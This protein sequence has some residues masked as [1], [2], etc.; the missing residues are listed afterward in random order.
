[1]TETKYKDYLAAR[2][3][4]ESQPVTY[5]LLSRAL[6]VN[7]SA[8]KLML[9]EFHQ[10]QNARKPNSIHATY[11]ISG[12]KRTASEPNGTNGRNGEDVSMRSSPFMS[13]MPGPEE[14]EEEP[15]KKCAILLV[16]EE[17]LA[18]TYRVVGKV[19]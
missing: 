15:V 10:K 14:P 3:L 6:Q 13:S 11:L 1:M 19:S 16:R 7:V 17:E 2:I 18:S 4:T 5:R 8:A 9:F 12:T